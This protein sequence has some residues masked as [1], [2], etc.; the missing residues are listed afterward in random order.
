MKKLLIAASP[1]E[2]KK[3]ALSSFAS[4][5]LKE[6]SHREMKEIEPGTWQAVSAFDDRQRSALLHPV[7]AAGRGA[8]EHDDLVSELAELRWAF[9]LW[10]AWREPLF[11][12]GATCIARN[13]D[14]SE[15]AWA[16]RGFL[17][18][19]VDPTTPLGP[20]ARL[21]LGLGLGAK[22]PGQHG[23]VIDAA[24]AALEEGRL[25]PTQFGESNAPMLEKRVVLPARW[26]KTFAEV[27]R[28][29]PTH[30]AAV[31]T[32]LQRALRGPSPRD[33]GALLELV[34]E[35][36]V[37]QGR[38]VDDPGAVEWL[39]QFEGGKAAKTAKALLA[40]GT[41]P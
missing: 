14:W 24:I 15:V 23:L 22:E 37:E 20:M 38:T 21:L 17:E 9:T 25:E 3:K 39:R 7:R 28:A 10:P 29:S 13:L 35:L 27:A 1:E 41:A 18:P 2:K 34:H 8:W 32:T 30:A 4:A 33:A 19:L 6:V 40:L 11:A 31:A 36:L 5:R 16:D 12:E 26:A